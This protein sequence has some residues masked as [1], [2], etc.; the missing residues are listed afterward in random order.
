MEME[1]KISI[2]IPHRVD[3]SCI[4]EWLDKVLSPIV[5]H[6]T[7]TGCDTLEAAHGQVVTGMLHIIHP[8]ELSQDSL[9]KWLVDPPEGLKILSI[10]RL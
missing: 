9:S 8:L 6:Q 2:Q 1:F 5:G 3:S 4:R 10:E 7:L